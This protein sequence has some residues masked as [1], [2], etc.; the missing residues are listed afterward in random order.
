MK[1]GNGLYHYPDPS[2]SK[3]RVY[4]QE[5]PLGVEFRMWRFEHPE[6]WSA[7]TGWPMTC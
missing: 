4:V 5:A 2:D 6:S 7:T 1:D 3:T